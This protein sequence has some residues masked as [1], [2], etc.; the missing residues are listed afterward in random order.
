MHSMRNMIAK[1]HAM[2]KLHE[3]GIPK[4]VETP[5]VFYIKGGRIHKDKKK[6]QGVR[7]K[8]KGKTKLAY[9]SKAKVPPL[10]KRD[11]PTKDFI[12]YH[13]KEVDHLRRNCPSYHPELKRRKNV[14]MGLRESRK[15][16]HGALSLY[17][18][19]GMRAAVEA[20]GSFD[21]VLPNG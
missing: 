17:V 20:I 2:I 13:C 14:S 15:L 18:G 3:K 7:G 9:A 6:P 11:N 4:K 12:C 1:L 10:P 5:V 16:K 21:L 8:D 19:N